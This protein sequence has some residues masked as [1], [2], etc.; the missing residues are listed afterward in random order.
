MNQVCEVGFYVV[1]YLNLCLAER[2]QSMAVSLSPAAFAMLTRHL[3]HQQYY[4]GQISRATAED[5]MHHDGQFLIRES[6][7]V[8]GQI[9]L[10]GSEGGR[11]KHL[12]LFDTDGRVSA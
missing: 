2:A 11:P 3:S 12:C 5:L 6:Q 4:H 7:N 10:T 1:H 8:N 9:V